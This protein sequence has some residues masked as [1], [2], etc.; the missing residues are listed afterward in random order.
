MFFGQRRFDLIRWFK[1]TLLFVSVTAWR[2][3]VRYL[4][5]VC[6]SICVYLLVPTVTCVAAERPNFVFFITDDISPD[7]LGCYGSQT[8]QTPNIDRMAAEG[9]RFTNAQLTI[10]SCS[11]SRCSIITGRYPHNTGAPELHTN[12]P[13]D[14]FMFPQR[15]RETGYYTVL[16]GKNHMGPA[17][18]AAFTRISRGKGPGKEGDWVDILRDR[19]KDQPF[20]CWFAS[21]DAHRPWQFNDEAPRYTPDDAEVPPFL[22][23]GPLTRKDLAEYYHEVSRTD[24]YLGQLRAELR[25]QGIEDNTYIIYMADNGRPFP[26]CKTRLYD[27]GIHTPFIVFGPTVKRESVCNALVSSIDIAPTILQLAGQQKAPSIQGVSFATLL[28]DPNA[29][30]RDYAF[31][32][33][34][35]HVF[36]SHE[37]MVRY[38]DWLYIRNAWPERQNLC[39]ESDPTYPSGKEL[40]DAHAK[41]LLKPHQT[42]IFQKP[43]P[44]EELYNVANDTDQLHNMATEPAHRDMLI[45]LRGIL[46][47]WS[48]E[49][50]DTIPDDP[51]PDRKNADGKRNS[52]SEHRT[53]PGT[54]TNAAHINHPGPI[55]AE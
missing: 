30:I 5:F 3:A 32:E 25:R 4:P 1:S 13:A 14:Q 6:L 36:Q 24:F 31:A 22:Y 55:F 52:T 28:K 11:P 42:D 23:D 26:R 50:G 2:S 54:E 43:R 33:H 40:W 19:P 7:D 17:V 21:T 41:G 15:L 35:W 16:S 49:T 27:S 18:S 10:S 44:A 51:T 47:R 38:G 37:R 8:V 46:D 20:F 53:M 9:M 29:K 48:K 45:K 34:N 39:V 12:L